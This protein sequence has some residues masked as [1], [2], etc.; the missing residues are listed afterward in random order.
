M[1]DV[2]NTEVS[3]YM[4]NIFQH[5]E[6]LFLTREVLYKIHEINTWYKMLLVR[7]HYHY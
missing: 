5:S 4:E 6:M 2:L 7:Y 3:R 1:I